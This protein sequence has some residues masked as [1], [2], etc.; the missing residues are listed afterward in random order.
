MADP[1]ASRRQT[2]ITSNLIDAL[3]D[4][5]EKP[6]FQM[7]TE[8]NA[9]ICFRARDLTAQW[10]FTTLRLTNTSK[11][12]QTFKTWCTSSEIFRVNPPHGY[13][14]PGETITLKVLAACKTVP[15]NYRHF[16]IIHHMPVD[17]RHTPAWQVWRNAPKPQSKKIILCNFENDA[18]LSELEPSSAAV[19]ASVMRPPTEISGR[20]LRNRPGEPRFRM[21]LKPADSICFCAK[22]LTAQPNIIQMTITNTTE[23]LQTFKIKCTSNDIFRLNPPFGYIRPD[24]MVVIKVTAKCKT[25]PENDCHHITFQHMPA[26][27]RK[28][29]ARD[30][31]NSTAKP[32]GLKRIVCIFQDND[33]IP[34]SFTETEP[35]ERER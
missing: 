13:I 23:V 30:L 34:F 35:T 29:R 31:W 32:Q 1:S 26:E 11:V 16:L 9:K 5:A 19:T 6:T 25:V 14:D 28:K 12:L 7:E 33:D 17:N 18:P 3:M 24:E 4:Q 22:D 2:M 21:K 27:D 8:P 20:T 15:D 10:N